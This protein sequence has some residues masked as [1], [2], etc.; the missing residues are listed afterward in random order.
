MDQRVIN[1][2][3]HESQKIELG[4]TKVILTSVP[5]FLALTLISASLIPVS[6]QESEE[7]YEWKV[8]AGAG[9]ENNPTAVKIL[10][11]IEISKQRLEELKNAPIIELTEHQKF[12]E[13]QR[14]IA[15]RT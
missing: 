5:L 8:V 10:Q 9:I 12:V 13:S 2:K 4:T 1:Y 11:N 15:S 3:Y 6:A 7:S 14:K